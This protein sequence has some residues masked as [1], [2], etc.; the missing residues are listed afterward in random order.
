MKNRTPP[1]SRK[2]RNRRAAAHFERGNAL[3]A[4][5]GIV[6]VLAALAVAYQSTVQS[7]SRTY[8][9]LAASIAH[10]NA[11]DAA[12]NLGVWRVVRDWRA[13][14]AN[15]AGAVFLCRQNDLLVQ[16]AIDD[17]TRRLNVNLADGASIASEIELI[18]LSPAIAAAIGGR[19]ADYIDPDDN[20]FDGGSE[21]ERPA[22]AGATMPKNGPMAVIEELRLVPGVDET[23]YRALSDAL[24]IH[25]TRSDRSRVTS[26]GAGDSVAAPR[27]VFRVTAIAL[28][29]GE[30]SVLA[31]RTAIIELDP[32]RPFEPAVRAWIRD[33]N[34]SRANAPVG[35][36]QPGCR[37]VILAN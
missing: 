29:D 25:S 18:G 4:I 21:R 35:A 34:G 7:Q 22:T 33:A 16:I 15:L 8:D 1:Q 13:D 36:V 6:G 26:D 27:G 14:G 5:I 9:A 37:Q 19:I 17:E 24:S 12:A 10:Q 2:R 3:L 20:A 32:A 28:R 23:T 31:K 30:G 11:V